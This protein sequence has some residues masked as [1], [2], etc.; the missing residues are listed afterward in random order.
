M[1]APADAERLAE[2]KAKRAAH[3]AEGYRR[4]QGDEYRD[5]AVSRKGR[6]N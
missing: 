6:R 3:R 1:V 2:R 4:G 5:H